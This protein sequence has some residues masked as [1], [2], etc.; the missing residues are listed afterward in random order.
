MSNFPIY[1]ACDLISVEN[2]E[3]HLVVHELE[4]LLSEEYFIPKKPHRHTFYQVMFVEE[5]SGKHKIDFKEYDIDSPIIYFISSGQVHD[6]VFDRQITKG[7]LINFDLEFFSS[8]L[9]PSY[10]I[11]KLPF[12]GISSN[13]SQY[14]V[15]KKK[16]K[17]IKEIFV[18]IYQEYKLQNKKS[19]ELI[20]IHLLEL[21]YC[22]LNDNEE[23]EENTNITNQKNLI[24]RFEKLV[25]E[26]YTE[27]HYPKFYADKL[28]ITPN[29][30]N[31]I[32][33]NFSG[34]KAGEIIRNRIILESKRLL[35]NS[36][37]SISQI[38]FQ[39]G[40]ID[41]SYFTKFFKTYANISPSDF[42]QNLNR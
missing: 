2:T 4:E 7:F 12:F 22:I 33:K 6:L 27:E 20:R 31:F 17:R 25:E 14:E 42:R 3:S 37:L 39:L 18:K 38:A 23:Y 30:L 19:L 8:F 9:S 34:K 40:F 26:K 1:S 15:E 5:G 16:F 11:D 21:F 24:S 28:A 35:V 13:I 41:N 29:Y 32:C 36:E 10:C